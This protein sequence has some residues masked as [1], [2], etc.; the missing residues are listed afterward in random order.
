MRNAVPF[1]VLLVLF[2]YQSIG[3]TTSFK[4]NRWFDYKKYSSNF[5]SKPVHEPAEVIVSQDS[6]IAHLGSKVM[7]YR[8]KGVT[9]VATKNKSSR[10]YTAES[11][12]TELTISI[13]RTMETYFGKKRRIAWISGGTDGWIVM[14]PLTS[15]TPVGYL[16]PG[17][18]KIDIEAERA[19]IVGYY[20]YDLMRKV[21]AEAYR[22]AGATSYDL[23]IWTDDKCKKDVQIELRADNTGTWWI[24]HTAKGCTD[25]V[26][27]NFKWKLEHVVVEGRQ[28]MMLTLTSDET[29]QYII[30]E[31][32]DK[33]LALGG[34]FRIAGADDSTS[35][36]YL[37][38]TKKKKK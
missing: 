10:E 14:S 36:A 27:Q 38:L 22:N 24:G 25:K 8:I 35:D 29:N 13:S 26:E 3:Q 20:V 2:S 6:I 33:K 5:Y 28:A 23:L 19:R 32:T 37:V 11:N 4:D 15:I 17:D 16:F 7:R 34:E 30:D 12:G 18:A 1:F 9:D 21:D 31:L